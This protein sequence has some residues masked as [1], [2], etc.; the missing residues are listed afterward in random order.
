GP[1]SPLCRRS[2]RLNSHKLLSKFCTQHPRPNLREG[3][4]AAG[5][6]VIAERRETAI[7]GS[8]ELLDRNVLRRF[9]NTVAD[10]L[11]SFDPQ[12]HGSDDAHKN[13]L[14]RFEVFAYDPQNSR[15]VLL[16]GKGN[17]KISRLELEKPRKQFRVVDIGTMAGAAIAPRA[18]M[19]AD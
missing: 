15:T 2:S 9:H 5:G 11:W 13:P 10:F 7:V 17:V 12:A 6:G 19:D 4:I 18:G 3:G 14:I 16:A 8:P 1:R